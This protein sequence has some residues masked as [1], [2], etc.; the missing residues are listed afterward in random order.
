MNISLAVIHAAPAAISPVKDYFAAEGPE[1]EVT[2][3]LDDGLLRMFAAGDYA[4][5]EQQL[6]ALIN[7]AVSNYTAKAALITCSAVPKDSMERI[8]EA[9]SI[10]VIKID[11]PM[12]DAARA[13]G[14]RIGILYNFAPTLKPTTALLQS[15]EHELF[16]R[17]VDSGVLQAAQDLAPD[18]DVIVLAQVSMAHHAQAIA[19]ATGKPTLNSLAPA[20]AFLRQPK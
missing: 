20:L 19:G 14:R 6:L 7:L 18:V 11:E 9:A 13:A 10:P 8:R 2:N 4:A 5:A 15:P 1:F 12:A 3:L 17:F 16:P